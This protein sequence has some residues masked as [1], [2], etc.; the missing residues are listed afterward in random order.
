MN[1]FDNGYGFRWDYLFNYT[2]HPEQEHGLELGFAYEQDIF[3]V[4]GRPASYR[5][6][7]HGN[8]F[9]VGKG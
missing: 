7:I 5:F 2:E 4:E 1:V 8:F 6:C 9:L 3:C